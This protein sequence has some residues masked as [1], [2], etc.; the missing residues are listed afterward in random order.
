MKFEKKGTYIIAKHSSF[1]AK[2]GGVLQS[3]ILEEGY[4]FNVSKQ[5]WVQIAMF[6]A[7]VLHYLSEHSLSQGL[8]A[9]TFVELRR[10][11][12]YIVALRT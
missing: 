4:I 10:V 5:A 11:D 12:T 2:I 7:R 1:P 6:H 3:H 8:W 9:D